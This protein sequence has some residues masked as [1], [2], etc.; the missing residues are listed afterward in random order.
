MRRSAVLLAAVAVAA[1]VTGAKAADMPA[2][3][4]VYKAPVAQL[5]APYNWTG[6]YVGVNGGYGWG[7]TTGNFFPSGLGNFDIDGGLFG[8]QLG[9]NYQLSNNFVIGVEADWD[10][11]NIDGSRSGVTPL[12]GLT[13]TQTM[14]LK[15]LGT[16]RGRIG[17]AWDRTLLY[18]TGG[19][20]WSTRASAGVRLSGAFPGFPIADDHSLTGYTLGLGLEYALTQNL[21]VKGEYL[22]VHLN[23]TDF[24]TS[25]IGADVNMVRLGLNWRF[26]SL[27]F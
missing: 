10:W 11:A 7:K 5:A 14:K 20:A 9:F 4:P 13:A 15:D 24:F 25:D 21:S 27:H 22:Y 16:L 23:P 26:T 2:K 19:F 3:A 8:A 17:Y 18:G 1:A 12:G 6:F